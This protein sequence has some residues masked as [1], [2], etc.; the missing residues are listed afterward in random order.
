M[1]GCLCQVVL[2]KET[3]ANFGFGWALGQRPARAASFLPVS[4]GHS[5]FYLHTVVK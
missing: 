4:N 1:D 3:S 5:P 2:L